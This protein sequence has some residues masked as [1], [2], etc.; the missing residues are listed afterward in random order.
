ML[1]RRTSVDYAFLALLR[2]KALR[3]GNWLSLSLVEKGLFRCALWVAKVRGTISNENL[4][5]HV[6]SIAIRLQRSLRSRIADAGRRKARALLGAYEKDPDG[7]F[8]WAPEMRDWL[9]HPLYVWYLG[10]LEVNG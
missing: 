3:N 10:V 9:H 1:P 4:I 8:S 7:V 5:R 6:L 2:R